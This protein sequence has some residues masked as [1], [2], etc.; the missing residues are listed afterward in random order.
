MNLSWMEQI[1]RYLYIF[2]SMHLNLALELYYLPLMQIV[3]EFLAENYLPILRLE[4]ASKLFSE[5]K[6]HQ[7]I[8]ID[9]SV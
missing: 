4:S 7:K 1:S 9:A 8:V 6:N 2:I 3:R 5:K